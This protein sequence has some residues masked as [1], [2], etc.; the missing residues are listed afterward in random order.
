M[1]A[2]MRLF[3]K[4]IGKNLLLIYAPYKFL[5]EFS[6]KPIVNIRPLYRLLPICEGVYKVHISNTN[7]E[8]EIGRVW[9]YNIIKK[10]KENILL[11]YAPLYRCPP[12]SICKER[13]QD[14]WDIVS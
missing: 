8:I 13:R 11:I 9:Y 3:I 12:I 6:Q 10:G 2:N 4:K 5:H 1:T 14:T 7:F